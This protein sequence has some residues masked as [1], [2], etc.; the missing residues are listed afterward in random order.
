MG[1]SC[2]RWRRAQRM[3]I[4]FLVMC[5]KGKIYY[6]KQFNLR[7][8]LPSWVFLC[9]HLWLEILAKMF[10]LD[11][12]NTNLPK[13]FS[14]TANLSFHIR[15]ISDISSWQHGFRKSYNTPNAVTWQKQTPHKD[16]RTALDSYPYTCACALLSLKYHVKKPS[17]SLTADERWQVSA[18]HSLL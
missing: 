1:N 8:N 7:K 14:K 2:L 16:A 18:F 10:I 13:H 15:P 9:E 11:L 3:T 5:P 6:N 12:V 17:F 4:W